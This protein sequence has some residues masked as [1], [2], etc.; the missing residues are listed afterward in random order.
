M[1]LTHRLPRLAF[2]LG[3]ALSGDSEVPP[4][5]TMASGVASIAMH[6]E[7]NQDGEIRA[8]LTP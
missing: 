8:R 5:K 1:R 3:V 2:T 6:S 4:V 7:A